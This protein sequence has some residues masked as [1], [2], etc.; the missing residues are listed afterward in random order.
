MSTRRWEYRQGHKYLVD[1]NGRILGEVTHSA[2]R[3]TYNA[4]SGVTSFGEYV[5]ESDAKKAVERGVA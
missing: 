5:E 2:W 1:E 3:D 4:S